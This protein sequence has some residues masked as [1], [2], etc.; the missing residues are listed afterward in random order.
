ML[1]ITA[2]YTHSLYV[3]PKAQC[4]TVIDIHDAA[5][6]I[7]V[8]QRC[9]SDIILYQDALRGRVSPYSFMELVNTKEVDTTGFSCVLTVINNKLIHSIFQMVQ[10]SFAGFKLIESPHV[11]GFLFATNPTVAVEQ[12]INAITLINSD[13]S[14][15]LDDVMEYITQ[16]LDTYKIDDYQLDNYYGDVFGYIMPP[17]DEYSRWSRIT[18]PMS[19][20]AGCMADLDE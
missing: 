12:P 16:C 2:P 20:S 8:V 15:T 11:I 1:Q 17:A 9:G 13:G 10:D 14:F 4:M 19:F 3:P 5:P 6:L 7:D 18:T